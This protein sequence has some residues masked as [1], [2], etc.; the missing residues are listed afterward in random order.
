MTRQ[1]AASLE[2]GDAKMKTIRVINNDEGTS[3]VWN[4]ERDQ[5]NGGWVITDHQGD[6]KFF[7]GC[8]A[9]VLDYMQRITLPNWGM[10]LLSV[11][12]APFNPGW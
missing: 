7:D 4:A 11:G 5:R 6:R 3:Q 2:T 1:R 9:E 12:G 10:R 8:F